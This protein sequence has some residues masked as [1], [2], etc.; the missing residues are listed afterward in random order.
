[1]NNLRLKIYVGY[2]IIG[3]KIHFSINK[4]R[5]NRINYLSIYNSMIINQFT[6]VKH[7]S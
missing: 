1:M 7:A 6:W 5:K 3:K 2:V 4:I